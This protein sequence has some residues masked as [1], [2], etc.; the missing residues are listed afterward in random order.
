MGEIIKTKIYCN[1]VNCKHNS[2]VA[3]PTYFSFNKIGNFVPLESNEVLGK[4]SRK[5]YDLMHVDVNTGNVHYEVAAC[6]NSSNM[7]ALTCDKVNCLHNKSR[8][9]SKKEIWISR[10]DPIKEPEMW[11]CRCF[12][13]TKISGHRDWSNLLQ[14]DGTSKGGHIDDSYA[15]KMYQ[16]SLKFKSYNV[17]H[18]EPQEP[19]KKVR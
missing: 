11:H 17:G 19:K 15:E 14:S 8:L 2:E 13:H 10:F 9:C 16:D 1:N 6:H 3:K 18:H 5:G 12:S 7:E 4:C